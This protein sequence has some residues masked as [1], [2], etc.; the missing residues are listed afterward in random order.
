[1]V[2]LPFL[3]LAVLLIATFFIGL[4]IGA[5]L[6]GPADHVGKKGPSND[7]LKDPARLDGDRV[8]LDFKGTK[9]PIGRDIKFVKPPE[10]LNQR[11]VDIKNL[12]RINWKPTTDEEDD[13]KILREWR[14]IRGGGTKGERDES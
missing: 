3:A 13:L 2:N 12:D 8:V 7:E 14:S 11:R 6:R 1:M 5:M 4:G 10:V 9:L